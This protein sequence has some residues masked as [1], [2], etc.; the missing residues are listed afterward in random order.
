MKRRVRL[1]SARIQ[2]F[3]KYLKPGELAQLRDSRI[4][5][6][7]RSQ[8]LNLTRRVV[9]VTRSVSTQDVFPNAQI[10]FEFLPEFPSLERGPQRFGKKKLVAAK[11]ADP[12]NT[13]AG[14]YKHLYHVV[15]GSV[16]DGLLHTDNNSISKTWTARIQIPGASYM[17]LKIPYF[18]IENSTSI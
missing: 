5:Y 14:N 12:L 3:S 16:I 15:E 10:E 7:A 13:L 18:I 4:N 9:S 8:V 17:N 11:I 1:R 6:K 2:R